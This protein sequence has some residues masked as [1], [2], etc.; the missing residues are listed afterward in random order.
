MGGQG[1]AARGHGY[2]P[3]VVRRVRH[4]VP[5]QVVPEGVG[6]WAGWQGGGAAGAAGRSRCWELRSLQWGQWVRRCAALTQ[7]QWS[8]LQGWAVCGSRCRTPRG[9]AVAGGWWYLWTDGDVGGSGLAAR[10]CW[11]V[12]VRCLGCPCVPFQCCARWM[13][14]RRGGGP[15]LVCHGVGSHGW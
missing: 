15:V 4:V 6:E 12:C 10:A 2:G 1:C 7:T 13:M 9:H 8:G 5:S 14:G 3:C 11:R